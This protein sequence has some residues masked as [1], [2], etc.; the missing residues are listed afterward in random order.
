MPLPGRRIVDDDLDT[1]EARLGVGY[2][3]F[4]RRR[5][6]KPRWRELRWETEIEGLYSGTSPDYELT[7]NAVSGFRVAT[8]L[9]YRTTW[10]VF[11]FRIGYI[12]IR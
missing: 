6:R 1:T 5:V 8:G 4:I 10:G 3:L 2:G 11:R 7:Y 9:V 12:D